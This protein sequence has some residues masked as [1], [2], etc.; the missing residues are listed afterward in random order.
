MM[1]Q[2]RCARGL[3]GLQ[4]HGFNYINI[5]S[6]WMGSFDAYGRPIPIRR[7]F[8]HHCA[9]RAR[10]CQRAESWESTG[11]PAWNSRPWMPTCRSWARLTTS[12]NHGRALCAGQCIQLGPESAL[13]PQEST[14]TKPG[15]QAYM[16]SVVAPVASWGWTRS[17]WTAS[18]RSYDDSLT[19]NNLAD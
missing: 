4:Q 2:S 11:S 19:I 18:R 5:D 17:S 1:A 3:G 15:A 9:R 12:R 14:F 8:R 10:A 7:S 13:S 6:G 16:D